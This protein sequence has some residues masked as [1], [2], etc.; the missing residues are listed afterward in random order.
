MTTAGEISDPTTEPSVAPHRNP[1]SDVLDE[2]A[3]ELLGITGEEFRHLWYSGAFKDDP[4][5]S[6]ATLDRFMRTGVWRSH[7]TD[8]LAAG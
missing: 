3:W 1:F 4:R 5:S 8:G 2:K 6:V 7:D